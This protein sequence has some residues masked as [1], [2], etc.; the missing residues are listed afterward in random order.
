VTGVKAFVV[1]VVV[2]VIGLAPEAPEL[3]TD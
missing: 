2:V 3:I 1:V